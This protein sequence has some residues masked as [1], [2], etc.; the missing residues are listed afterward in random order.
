MTEETSISESITEEAP[1]EELEL[2]EMEKYVQALHN[3]GKVVF[4]V[5]ADGIEDTFRIEYVIREGGLYI[6]EFEFSLGNGENLLF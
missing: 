1:V 3:E 6:K 5:N 2:T 4:D